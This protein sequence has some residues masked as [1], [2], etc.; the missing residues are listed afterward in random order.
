M[1]WGNS[2]FGGDSSAV[3]D[4][5]RNVVAVQSGYNSFAA[6]LVDG[7]VVTWGQ[8]NCGGDSSSVQD[9]LKHVQEIHELQERFFMKI[10]DP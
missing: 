8:P 9:Q 4:K 6:I 10:K 7:S 1:T 5:L 3:Q 2:N